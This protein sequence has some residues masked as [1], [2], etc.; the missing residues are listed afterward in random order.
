ME[1]VMDT[2]ILRQVRPIVVNVRGLRGS[3]SA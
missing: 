3:E 1:V 2:G